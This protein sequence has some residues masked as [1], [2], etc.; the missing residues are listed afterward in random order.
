MVIT[1]LLLLKRL[2][3]D[4]KP[5]TLK[6]G[7]NQRTTRYHSALNHQSYTKYCAVGAQEGVLMWNTW[8]PA[9]IVGWEVLFSAGEAGVGDEGQDGVLGYADV[10]A[11]GVDSEVQ[12]AI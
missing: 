3:C 2:L 7:G 8:Q 6:W 10:E 5:Y 11:G 12:G 9:S 4:N 1:Y